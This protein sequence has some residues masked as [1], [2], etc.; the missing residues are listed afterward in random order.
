MEFNSSTINLT[1][2]FDF[3]RLIGPISLSNFFD[4]YWEKEPLLLNRQNPE[5][6]Q[7]LFSI[8]DV[9]R[10]LDLNRPTGRSI[11]VVKNQ[12]PLLSTK[13]ENADGSLN[14]NQ[15]Y[16][17]Y[18]KGYTIV[19]NE[20]NRFWPS[21]KK[22][23]QQIS[24]LMSYHT[25]AN[26]YLTPKNQ[27]ALLPH[28]DT[29]DV[30]AIQIY[31]KKHW[32]IYDSPVESPLLHSFQPVFKREQLKNMKEVCLNAGDMMYMPRGV[33]HEA[34]TSDEPS[35]HITIG[36]YPSQWYDLIQGALQQ[37]AFSD[38]RLRKALPPGFLN[39]ENW[40]PEFIK[41]MKRNFNELIDQAAKNVN[42]QQSIQLLS[43]EFR[44]QFPVEGDGH[45]QQIDQLDRLELN[46]RLEK[47]QSMPC[48]IQRLANHT[49][50]AYPGNSIKGPSHITSALEFIVGIKDSFQIHQ[51]PAMS[52]HNKI[53]LCRRLIR[54]GLLRKIDQ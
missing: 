43:E 51:L 37:L 2:V 33:P 46:S 38:A 13:Y 21:L 31:G 14:L 36:I 23:C 19:I 49:M 25:V 30:F 44:N 35:L 9:D 7:Q 24:N 1:D 47:R 50:I 53:Q 28:Y 32:R 39:S 8:A 42:I 26:M 17:A 52:D 29:H 41:D 54:G 11:R 22:T 12:E 15:L 27:K 3:E 45:F 16:T 20:I 4:R 34:F 48:S 10:I 5:Y 40:T 18:A 6:Y